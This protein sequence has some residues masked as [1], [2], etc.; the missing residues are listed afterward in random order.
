MRVIELHLITWLISGGC[1]IFAVVH[2]SL[3]C[4]VIFPPENLQLYLCWPKGERFFGKAC[5][6]TDLEAAE[7]MKIWVQ[8]APRRADESFPSGCFS[9][10]VWTSNWGLDRLVKDCSESLTLAAVYWAGA[11]GEAYLCAEAVRGVRGV[12]TLMPG[13]LGLNPGWQFSVPISLYIHMCVCVYVYV[14]TCICVYIYM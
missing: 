12:G 14:H 8:R 5:W 13:C 6:F 7:S 3:R 11:L 4:L 2:F 1:G 10:P 9:D